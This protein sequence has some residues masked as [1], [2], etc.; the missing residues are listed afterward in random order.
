MW[1]SNKR[2]QIITRTI[3]A[4]VFGYLISTLI[5]ILGTQVLPLSNAENTYLMTLIS[6]MV[7]TAFILYCFAI[8]NL[9][10]L[11]AYTMG[12]SSLLLVSITISV[13]L[14]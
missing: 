2:V 1:Y 7:Y 14:I 3:L 4:I 10:R 5:T 8:Q 11:I 13:E 6:F 12:L 9:Q